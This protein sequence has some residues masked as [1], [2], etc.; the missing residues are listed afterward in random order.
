MQDPVEVIKKLK[1]KRF[2]PAGPLRK[3]GFRAMSLR[4]D[5]KKLHDP[6]RC[7]L[8]IGVHHDNGVAARGLLNMC[9]ADGDSSLMAEIAAQ[10]HNP[11]RSH[12]REGELK[13]SPVVSL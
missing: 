2:L 7:I 3:N 6:C 13:V 9:Q 1:D 8:S 5:A 11:Y 4:V 12:R 10:T